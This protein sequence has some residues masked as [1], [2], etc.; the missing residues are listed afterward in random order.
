MM[1][2][3]SQNFLLKSME[4]NLNF[5]RGGGLKQT[6]PSMKGAGGIVSL[7]IF[8]SVFPAGWL[9]SSHS[10]Q[11]HILRTVLLRFWGSL[12]KYVLNFHF[13]I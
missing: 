13:V 7:V 2:R 12:W 9:Y 4:L 6:K 3:G 5:K 11:D 8:F 1:G 10:E